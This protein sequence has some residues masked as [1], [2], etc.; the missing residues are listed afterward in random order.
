M[1]N[2]REKGVWAYTGKA[3][4]FWVPS[5]ISGTGK[6]M[7]LNFCTHILSIDGNKS[8]LQISGKIAG[9]IV[10]TLE[11]FQGTHIGLLGT[12]CGLLCDISPVLFL[13]VIQSRTTLVSIHIFFQQLTCKENFFTFWK[14]F[15]KCLSL[16]VNGI[17]M[18]RNM[19][20]S[21]RNGFYSA[22]A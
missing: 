20:S 10:G 6:G 14:A 15:V 21:P 13:K 11:N 3:Q 4:I 1:K 16:S 22:S 17:L 9:C 2:L 18:T 7:N 5:I 12:S 19:T 8:P